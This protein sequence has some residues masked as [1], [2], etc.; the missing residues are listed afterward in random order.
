MVNEEFH[1]H[2]RWSYAGDS[3]IGIIFFTIVVNQNSFSKEVLPRFFKHGNFSS[4]VRQLN[5]YDFRKVAPVQHR[6]SE[7]GLEFKNEHFL[8]G[9]PDLLNRI[10]RKKHESESLS[11]SSIDVKS[12]LSKLTEIR[13]EQ[14]RINSDLNLL[15]EENS[16]IW[17]EFEESRVR[18]K[19]QEET[20]QKLVRF[21]GSVFSVQQ[22]Y[23]PNELASKKSRLLTNNAA[24]T[25]NVRE[26]I[27][28]IPPS[29]AD[30]PNLLNKRHISTD[31]IARDVGKIGSELENLSS[32]L[33][34]QKS[35][36]EKTDIDFE[37]ELKKALI[38]DDDLLDLGA[39]GDADKSTESFFNFD[40]LPTE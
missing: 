13:N 30:S 39:I 11:H 4:F 3:F 9:R 26:L 19:Q 36:L 5:M 10:K 1:G 21:L 20:I 33:G 25:K 6:E 2:I 14:K 34:I 12:V 27:E 22:G 17:K 35:D 38:E 7:K 15:R 23:Q 16:I 37:A 40:E 28:S 32:I 29:R 24:A 18:H 31:L 8:R